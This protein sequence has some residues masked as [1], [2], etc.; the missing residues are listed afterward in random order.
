[1]TTAICA[2]THSPNESF[3]PVFATSRK[4]HHLHREPCL[5]RLELALQTYIGGCIERRLINTDAGARLENE[6]ELSFGSLTLFASE[7]ASPLYSDTEGRDPRRSEYNLN[8]HPEA[9]NIKLNFKD[10]IHASQKH[11]SAR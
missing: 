11:V 10:S 5:F 4:H 6:R 9:L 7:D 2:Q 1:M 3:G 8:T